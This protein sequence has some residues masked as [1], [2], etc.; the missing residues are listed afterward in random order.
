[1]TNRPRDTD[2]RSRSPLQRDRGWVAAVSTSTCIHLLLLLILALIAVGGQDGSQPLEFSVS[3]PCEVGL[4]TLAALASPAP[5][6]DLESLGHS[7]D[8]VDFAPDLALPPLTVSASASDPDSA[9]F[10][11]E[12]G[13]DNRVGVPAL[14]VSAAIERIQSR[15]AGAGGKPGEVQFALAWKNINDVDLHVIAPS[16]EH[17]S[18]LHRRSKC[19]GMLDVDM[20]VHGESSDPVENIRWIRHAPWGRYTVL[21]HLFRMHAPRDGRGGTERDSRFDLLA[22]LGSEQHV[23]SDRVS[24]DRRLL[25]FRYIYVPQ[26]LP[27][28]QREP[29]LRNIQ[30]QQLQEEQMAD[31]LQQARQIGN[32]VVRRRLLTELIQRYPHTDAAI[33]ALQLID[34]EVRK[35]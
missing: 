20:N 23:A 8:V 9:V 17:I 5:D 2:V 14:G 18:H 29:I 32:S 22:R 19:Q 26:T 27:P 33:E 28:S 35:R 15:V 12:A 6:V 3:S 25:V 24:T 16:G 31:P 7:G 30:E 34:G 13:T 21:V 10:E 4:E 11:P 1:M